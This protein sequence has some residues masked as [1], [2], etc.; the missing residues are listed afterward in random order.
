MTKTGH[1]TRSRFAGV[2]LWWRLGFAFY[3]LLLVVALTLC[4]TALAEST[5]L[6]S[7]VAPIIHLPTGEGWTRLG[8]VRYCAHNLSISIGDGD[9]QTYDNDHVMGSNWIAAAVLL[10]LTTMTLF[11]AFAL[12]LLYVS[13]HG[14]LRWWISPLVAVLALL[15]LLAAILSFASGL[16]RLSSDLGR[17]DEPYCPNAAQFDKGDCDW[18]PGF[19]MVMAALVVLVLAVAM[20]LLAAWRAHHASTRLHRS[21]IVRHYDDLEHV[22]ASKTRS[23]RQDKLTASSLGGSSRS[24]SHS[25]SSVSVVIETIGNRRQP[26][27]DMYLSDIDV[28]PLSWPPYFACPPLQLSHIVLLIRRI[29]ATDPPPTVAQTTHMWWDQYPSPGSVDMVPVGSERVPVDIGSMAATMDNDLYSKLPT[30]TAPTADDKKSRQPVPHRQASWQ[31]QTQQQSTGLPSTFATARAPPTDIEPGSH[32]APQARRESLPASLQPSAQTAKVTR[33]RSEGAYATIVTP[34]TLPLSMRR[35]SSRGSQLS[36]SLEATPMAVALPVSRDVMQ[37][38]RSL[39]PVPEHIDYEP[40]RSGR[41]LPPR[42][43]ARIS[44]TRVVVTNNPTVSERHASPVLEAAGQERNLSRGHYD[45]S[46]GQGRRRGLLHE[47]RFEADAQNH[48]GPGHSP[49]HMASR[50]G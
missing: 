10:A 37:D 47:R 9:C 35:E 22:R 18:G 46:R 29:R 45:A 31:D 34:A 40:L 24:S 16:D 36:S 32:S 30:M 5:W 25:S 50:L 21:Q 11:A 17:F 28:D 19:G 15:L 39:A 26:V 33:A 8:L 20:G 43:R 41:V 12:A 49:T 38:K 14:G 2:P 13:Q 4:I 3:A 7:P 42:S 27:C 1:Q 48:P 44:L 6:E 23:A